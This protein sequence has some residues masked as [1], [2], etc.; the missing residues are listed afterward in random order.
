MKANELR[1][2][3]TKYF[4]DRDHKK[5]HSASLIPHDDSL[6]FVNSGMVPFKP[7]FIGESTPESS[8]AVTVQKCVR[9]GG[10]HNDLDEV[11]RTARHLT[12]FEMMGNFSFG[13]YFKE[14][15]IEFAWEFVTE[16]LKFDATRL[17]VTVHD[18]DDEA[19][20]LWR[21]KI[22]VPANR[23]Q[24]LDEDNWWRMADTGPNGPCSEIFWDKG[25]QFG[26][27][28]G[29][30]KGGE[31]R[32]I[33]FWNLV[34]MQFE[35]KEGGETTPLLKPSIDTGAGLERILSILQN[36]ESVFEIDEM[37]RLIRSAES[38]TG[39][40]LGKSENSDLAL[41]VL[42]EHARTMTFLISDGVVPSNEDRGYVLRRI[43]R[44]AIRFAY[45][46]G[47]E[48]TVTPT[49]VDSVIEIMGPDY[50]EIV[51]S[52]DDICSIVEREEVQFRKTLSTGSNILSEHLQ[53]VKDGES[54]AGSV[55]FLL[56]DT[57]G[58]PFEVTEEVV[59][60]A[61]LNVDREGFDEAMAAHKS[62]SKEGR[63]ESNQTSDASEVQSLVDSQ[64]FTEFVGRDQLEDV[65]A[66]VLLVTAS[67]SES[68][69]N[70]FVDK[71]PFY[72]ES[73]GQIGDT[74]TISF[75]NG[76]GEV[77]DTV[78]ASPDIIR[79]VVRIESGDLSTGSDVTLS[80]D[81]ERRDAIRR[82]HTGT[83][84]LHWA[85][86]SVV[87]D[88]V[89]QQGSMVGPD[90]LRFDFSHFEP[91]TA[92]QIR[93]IEDISNK[94]I[95]NNPGVSHDE[96]TKSEAEAMGAIAFFGDKYGETVRVLKAGPSLE[97]CGGTHVKALGDIGCIKIISEGSIGSNL[98]RIEAISG[99]ATIELLRAEQKSISDAADQLNVS[100]G[101]L[102]NGVSKK[103]TE[104][105]SLQAELK[106]QKFEL[107]K[108]KAD[109]LVETA[110][111][112]ILIARLD[113]IERND[114]QELA[115]SL[116]GKDSI[117]AVVLG[118]A[119]TGG[120][121]CLVAAVEKGSSVLAGDLIAAGAKS[122]Q[123]GGGKGPEFAMA[124]GK[125]PEGIDDALESARNLLN[126]SGSK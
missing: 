59:S 49:L 97:F 40:K 14:E 32:F 37:Q 78:Y 12:F 124:G 77:L 43:M 42:A 4:T 91:L 19:E 118:G 109:D 18:S 17:W 11:G 65:K 29:P 79:H 47:V 35:T 26:A 108:T 107:I 63:K 51:D 95:L 94:E 48:K 44:R 125:N 13:D 6:L 24:R 126:N 56:H 61:G 5:I 87:G 68:V 76:S 70:V 86:R 3:F 15:A 100:K 122:I 67:P 80:I 101:E 52:H 53:E 7:Y 103:L 123:G 88:H 30:A 117:N 54:L 9:A 62:L 110:K 60:E 41:R 57:Y 21:E 64:S 89:K 72:A 93:Q 114:L 98:R 25:P 36:K 92:E 96:V 119:P 99:L 115:K 104:I 113:D 31:D 23:I 82:N 71:T 112:G 1:Q 58:F 120:G 10:K 46:L 75:S 39:Y 55:A 73:G 85:L 27:E 111:N 22:G 74:G 102:I 116:K 69:I 33:E 83:H 50:P 16:H 45:L 106:K 38:A 66:K 105:D 28:G 90:R 2:T 81:V 8:R 34:F 84:I 121:A 20:T